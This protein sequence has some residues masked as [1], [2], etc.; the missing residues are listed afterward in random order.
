MDPKNLL[1]IAGLIL[2]GFSGKL[3]DWSIWLGGPLIFLG[4]ITKFVDQEP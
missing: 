3:G 2:I 1:I 4:V